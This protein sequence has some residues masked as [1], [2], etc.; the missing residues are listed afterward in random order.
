MSFVCSEKLSLRND[1]VAVGLT[2][3]TFG[4]HTGL[5]FQD[6]GSLKVAHMRFHL[7]VAVED[8][9][10]KHAPCWIAAPLQ[11]HP[12]NAKTL[13]GHLNR[14]GLSG[15]QVS[16]GVNIRTSRGSFSS[17][18]DYQRPIGNDG[19]TCATFVN[20]LCRSI[21][22]PLVDEHSWDL[23]REEDR[24]W[25]EEVA[26]LLRDN[27]ADPRHIAWVRSNANGLR[28]RP[29]EVAASGNHKASR[30]GISFQVASA[31]GAQLLDQLDACCPDGTR[32]LSAIAMAAKRALSPPLPPM[33]AVGARD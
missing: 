33:P 19:L 18:G 12:M 11:M 7:N 13:I 27:N 21:G 2:F 17:Q 15:S 26:E 14:I 29:E 22:L 5:L 1:Q 6:R 9:P 16:F 28:I 24:L 10:T 32:R 4:R 23:D 25:V 31:E 3:G 30:T 20:E 8:F